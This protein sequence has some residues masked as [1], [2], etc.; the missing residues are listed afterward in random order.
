MCVCSQLALVEIN[1]NQSTVILLHLPSEILHIILKKLNNMD[2]LYSLLGVDN[3][4]LDTILLDKTF[5]NSLSFVL[6]TTTNDLLPITGSML[7]RFCIDI[8]PKIHCN[9]K[10]LTLH[11]EFMERILRA[12][13]FPNLSEL[14]L[15]NVSDNTISRY[16]T[17]K[18]I[19]S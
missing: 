14:R 19:L 15:Y 12:A 17:G 10:F 8:L 4:R 13:D 3:Q 16:F 11:S 2:V 9:V 5:T 1:M 18:K 7:D 6:T